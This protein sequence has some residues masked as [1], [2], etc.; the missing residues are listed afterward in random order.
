MLK[1]NKNLI[2]HDDRQSLYK[3]V[4]G[5][6]YSEVFEMMPYLDQLS[7]GANLWHPPN[8]ALLSVDSKG[9]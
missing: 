8:I 7:T 2:S 4:T 5:Q 1:A 3:E 9:H 6:F